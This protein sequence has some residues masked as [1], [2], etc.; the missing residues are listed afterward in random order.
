[1]R[2]NRAY[3]DE[4]FKKIVDSLKECNDQTSQIN[5]NLGIRLS[6]LDTELQ[7]TNALLQNKSNIIVDHQS[8]LDGLRAEINEQQA[9][10]KTMGTELA[11]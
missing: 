7:E 10:I 9:T 2:N 11:Q 8:L 1:M 3:V 5:K 6:S 4:E